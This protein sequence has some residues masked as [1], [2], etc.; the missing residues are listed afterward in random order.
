MKFF[1]TP[2]PHS[3]SRGTQTMTQKLNHW[4]KGLLLLKTY[5]VEKNVEFAPL[6]SLIEYMSA[7]PC[8]VKTTAGR[9]KVAKNRLPI[10]ISESRT[11]EAAIKARIKFEFIKKHMQFVEVR[12][13]GFY[14]PVGD[15]VLWADMESRAKAVG[16]P[17]T[18]PAPSMM[19]ELSDGEIEEGD[20]EDDDE[21]DDDEDED[22]EDEE[23]DAEEE[24]EEEE[25]A[26]DAEDADVEMEED[27]HQRGR[28][29]V[30]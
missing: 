6:K 8:L 4:E 27:T 18:T 30:F 1:T 23:E 3:L 22:E 29:N 24:D 20:E 11:F 12:D 26:E 14:K 9:A 28:G 17:A 15:P 25:D 21:D 13:G 5:C 10:V 16:F 2:P 7:H 19:V